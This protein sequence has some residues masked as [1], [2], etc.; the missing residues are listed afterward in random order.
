ML[1]NI[2][3]SV[4]ALLILLC[5]GAMKV[6]R[7]LFALFTLKLTI[8]YTQTFLIYK[9]IQFL[10]LSVSQSVIAEQLINLALDGV[11]LWQSWAQSPRETA[12]LLPSAAGLRRLVHLLLFL[13]HFGLLE[14]AYTITTNVFDDNHWLVHRQG[15]WFFSKAAVLGE[16]I[17]EWVRKLTLF[18]RNLAPR[19]HTVVLAH[20]WFSVTA[21]F[22]LLFHDLAN[23][24]ASKRLDWSQLRLRQ[25]FAF[26]PVYLDQLAHVSWVDIDGLSWELYGLSGTDHSTIVCKEQVPDERVH[27]AIIYIDS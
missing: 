10:F 4:L 12:A 13:L 19:G 5:W 25:Y 9:F 21:L 3:L 17:G 8:W 18:I 27:G 22:L 11:G 16:K 15:R 7:V 24:L 20:Y 6:F 14:R 23:D 26:T 1:Q 2:W